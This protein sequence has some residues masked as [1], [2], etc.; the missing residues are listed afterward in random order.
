MGTVRS[1]WM[2]IFFIRVLF[3]SVLRGL[4]VDYRLPWS[5]HLQSNTPLSF[6]GFLVYLYPIKKYL[7][8]T[9]VEHVLSS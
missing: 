7:S 6:V 2:L 3:P 8:S 1:F 9:V 4:Q 5:I